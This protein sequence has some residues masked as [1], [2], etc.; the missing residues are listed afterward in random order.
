VTVRCF[1]NLM[2]LLALVFGSP[3]MSQG[4]DQDNDQAA[5][6]S[7][8][9]VIQQN[10]A[11]FPHGSVRFRFQDGFAADSTEARAGR[12]TK[13]AEAD[14]LL[15]FDQGHTRFQI[16]FPTDVMAREM[17]WL[18]G[19]QSS[20]RLS[21]FRYL[22][23][24][25]VTLLEVISANRDGSPLTGSTIE[26]GVSSACSRFD[27][28]LTLGI[29]QGKHRGIVGFLQATLER[30]PVVRLI[31]LD[32]NATR[33]GTKLVRVNYAFTGSQQDFWADLERG[34]AVVYERLAQN[35]SV[36]EEFCEDIR[37]VPGHGWLPFLW[38]QYDGS[39]RTKRI[40]VEQADF[41][42]PPTTKDFTLS[43]S[44]PE[45]FFD[46][47]TNQQY[48]GLYKDWNLDH[49]PPLVKSSTPPTQATKT[50]GPPLPDLPGE[51]E[52]PT[53]PLTISVLA[54][55]SVVALCLLVRAVL[56]RRS[57]VAR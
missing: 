28:P 2:V 52:K 51:I 42:H 31:G 46:P 6:R 40:I 38:T 56:V 9:G 50:P 34:G 54:I 13:F 26:S 32:L 29:P 12:F 17:T 41:D 27:F 14:G 5:L 3:V 8:N 44:R 10:Y 19:N 47:R 36:F 49:L 15:V 48:Q 24:N 57:P 35:G 22:S 18:S 7:I 43:F 1:L 30:N 4:E 16:I 33:E 53:Y 11:R 39:G 37:Q 55:L 21:S 23:N 25:E 20:S 45:F